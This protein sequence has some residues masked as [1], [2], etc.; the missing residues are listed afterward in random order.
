MSNCILHCIDASI[1]HTPDVMFPL[2][3]WLSELRELV[4]LHGE[5]HLDRPDTNEEEEPLSY[6]EV[7]IIKVW[8]SVLPTV[9]L[10]FLLFTEKDLC[11]HTTV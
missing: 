1:T 4:K 8:H 9:K 2:C 6:D 10:P 5:S 11:R 7:L 3:S